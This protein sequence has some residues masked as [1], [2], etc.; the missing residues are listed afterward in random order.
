MVYVVVAAREGRRARRRRR[1]LVPM[2]AGD[3]DHAFRRALLSTDGPGARVLGGAIDRTARS[4]AAEGRRPAAL[5]GD[6]RT[7]GR[8]VDLAGAADRAGRARY[9][10][11]DRARAR[12]P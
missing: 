6:I 10:E 12:L 7:R 11:R 5:A 3:A 1:D 2:A 4:R 8:D 9:D